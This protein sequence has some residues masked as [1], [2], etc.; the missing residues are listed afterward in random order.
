MKQLWAPWR[1]QYILGTKKSTSCV[2]CGVDTSCL[3]ELK[4]RFVVFQN[5]HAYVMLNQFP[6]AAGHLLVIPH[7]HSS[8]IVDLDETEYT[9]L[10]KL[11]KKATDVLYLSVKPEGLNIGMNLGSIAGAG[12]SEHLHVH[13]VPRWA[14]D[15]NFMPVIADIRIVPQALEKT[16]DFLEPFFTES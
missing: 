11:V 3:D 15:T 14:G 12:V 4:E 2:F 5:K 8:N 16:R 1:M 6:F 9:E 10:F 7:R 13:I